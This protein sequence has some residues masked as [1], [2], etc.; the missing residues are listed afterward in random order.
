[1]TRMLVPILTELR[2]MFSARR[3][4]TVVFDRAG[5]SPTLFRQIVAMGIDILT[6]RKGRCRRVAEKRFVRCVARVDGRRVEHLLH[7]QPVRFLKGTFRLR[8]V[9]RLA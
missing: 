5:R 8:Q 1:M 9:T 3:R 7:D 6:S 4:L 2:P